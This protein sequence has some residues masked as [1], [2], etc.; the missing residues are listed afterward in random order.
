MM[1]SSQISDEL[2]LV[3]HPVGS[4]RPKASLL[5]CLSDLIQ[6]NMTAHQR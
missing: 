6:W 4:A 5:F 1:L 3:V 2:P